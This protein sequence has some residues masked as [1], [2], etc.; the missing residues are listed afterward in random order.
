M[1]Y[2]CLYNFYMYFLY[3]FSLFVREARLP[4]SDLQHVSVQGTRALDPG[5]VR[6]VSVYV[7]DVHV[8]AHPLSPSLPLS[9]S[10]SLSLS[11][12]LYIYIYIYIYVYTYIH[13]HTTNVCVYMYIYL[14]T[15]T[16]LPMCI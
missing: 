9:L 6:A 11:L 4:F 5:S 14:Y 12:S 2:Y 16:C 7:L 10:P 13:T 15:H 8:K 1:L 3:S